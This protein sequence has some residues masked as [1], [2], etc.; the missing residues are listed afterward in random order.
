[1]SYINECIDAPTR[2]IG[3]FLDRLP[4]FTQVA[5]F[6]RIKELRESGSV[7]GVMCGEDEF[8]GADIAVHEVSISYL[9]TRVFTIKSAYRYK[10]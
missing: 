8:V 4:R 10:K 7:S 6:T 2:E 9:S 5:L 1:M 3:I